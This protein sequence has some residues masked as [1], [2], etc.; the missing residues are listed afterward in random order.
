MKSTLLAYLTGLK[1]MSSKALSQPCTYLKNLGRDFTRRRAL[2]L[3]RVV[4]LTVGLFKCTL[5]IELYHFF[6]PQS[7]NERH[8]TEKNYRSA[9]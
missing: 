2:Y 4:W 5:N 8:Q 9:F 1:Q 6:T 7:G 3:D